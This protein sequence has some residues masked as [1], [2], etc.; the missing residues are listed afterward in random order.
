M[1]CLGAVR[2]KH[3]RLDTS[4]RFDIVRAASRFLDAVGSRLLDGKESNGGMVARRAGGNDPV[5]VVADIVG[6][7]LPS[8]RSRAGVTPCTS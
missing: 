2:H 1:K 7:H 6:G 5:V 8:V 3:R 4:V